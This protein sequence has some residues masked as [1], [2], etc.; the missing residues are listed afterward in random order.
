MTY[1]AT[2]AQQSALAMHNFDLI[3]MLQ[4]DLEGEVGA[5]DQYQEHLQRITDK[6]IRTQ[7]QEIIQDEQDHYRILLSIIDKLS[8]R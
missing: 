4:Q 1:I 2:A 6:Q 8:G 5:I 7:L 3:K